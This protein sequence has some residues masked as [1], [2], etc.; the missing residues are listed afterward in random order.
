MT[1]LEKG[2]LAHLL[3]ERLDF[4]ASVAD[5]RSTCLRIAEA[6]LPAS[7]KKGVAEVIDTVLAFAA[8]PPGRRLAEKHPP[9]EYPFTLKL[10]GDAVYFIK[11]AMDL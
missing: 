9:A 2:D 4:S 3:L 5:Q 6:S 7:E 10:T 11:G 1:P 8:S